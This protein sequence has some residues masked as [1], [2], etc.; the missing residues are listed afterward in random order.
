[1]EVHQLHDLAETLPYAS[2]G[3]SL[4]GLLT[5]QW[6]QRCPICI[7]V[8]GRRAHAK[9]M[10][11]PQNQFVSG[12]RGG[13]GVEPTTGV[14]TK[15]ATTDGSAPSVPDT[16]TITSAALTAAPMHPLLHYTPLCCATAYNARVYARLKLAATSMM[17][18]VRAC[19]ELLHAYSLDL[20]NLQVSKAVWTRITSM[21][22]VVAMSM[23]GHTVCSLTLKEGLQSS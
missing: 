2:R 3:G 17:V 7:K 22:G 13:G 9:L 23:C 14:S 16:T 15:P 1:M 8:G 21:Q 5:H 6:K 10:L 4:C 19:A 18:C 20:Q 12:G 11:A